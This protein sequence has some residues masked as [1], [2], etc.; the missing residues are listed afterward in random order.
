MKSYDETVNCMMLFLNERKVCSS[1]VLSHKKCY[2]EFLLF[3]QE[4]KLQWN[5]QAISEWIAMVRNEKDRQLGSIWNQYMYQ[6]YEMYNTGTVADRHLYL[7]RSTYERLNCQMRTELDEYLSSCKNR[8]SAR[9]WE[10]ARNYLA[11]MLIYFE[12]CGKRSVSKITYGDIIDY[13]HSDFCNS[14]KNRAVYLGHARRFFEFMYHKQKC[15]AGFYLYLHDKNAPYVGMLDSFSSPSSEQIITYRIESLEFPTED[16]LTAIDCFIDTLEAHYYANTALKTAKHALHI[17]YLFLEIHQLG[18]HPHIVSVWFSE[19]QHLLL[20]DW[21][22]WRRMLML[23]DQYTQFGGI[24]PEE[25]FTYKKSC[26]DLLPEWCVSQ[27][28]GY[29]AMLGKEFHAQ[30]T[31]RSYRYPCIRLCNYLIDRGLDCFSGLT[32]ELLQ[33]FCLQ[34]KHR[35][36]RGKSGSFVVIRQF[37]IFLEEQGKVTNKH[38]HLCIDAGCASGEKLIDILSHDQCRRIDEYRKVHDDPI[39]LRRIAVVMTGIKM[40]FRASD[41]INL[42][43]QDINWSEKSITIIQEKTKVSLTLPMPVEVGNAI[44]NYLKHGRPSVDSK[45]VFIRH[46]APYGKLTNKTCTIALW[47]I[48]PERSATTGG[49]HVTR[50]TFATNVLRNGYGAGRVMDTLGHRDPTSVM[51]YLSMD[52]DR[53]RMCPLSL[54]DLNL[55]REE[56]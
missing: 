32:P 15:P 26:L 30:G 33:S 6:L 40:G 13:Y 14:E 2:A 44:Y 21:K 16:L 9:S 53:M 47:S 48:L 39:S 19:I 29:L 42:K 38:L 28:G 27:I 12:D 56:V 45:Y 24:I 10:L 41:V 22:S 54:A 11:G 46:K 18:Y 25:K 55:C 1:S 3:M 34:D 20:K 49:F 7:N 35:T 8:Y 5:P 52:E 31:I 50:R 23:F 17:L 37:V 36:F 51:K 43:F 4:W